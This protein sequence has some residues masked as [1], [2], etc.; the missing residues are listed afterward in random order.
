MNQKPAGLFL[1]RRK[2]YPACPGTYT[3]GLDVL[4]I[5]IY[6]MIIPSHLHALG[7]LSIIY[8]L[9]NR[10]EQELQE[11]NGKIDNLESVGIV[12]RLSKEDEPF[13]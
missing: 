12:H 4:G 11:F 9:I 1:K 10:D 2:V 5:T 7:W 8:M 13:T 3:R 6:Y